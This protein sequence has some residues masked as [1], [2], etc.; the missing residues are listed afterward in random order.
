MKSFFTI[1]IPTLLVILFSASVAFA[2]TGS[3][4]GQVSDENNNPLTGA[5]IYIKE[6]KA[7]AITDEFGSFFL[8]EIKEGTYTIIV[9]HVGFTAIEEKIKIEDGVTN[10]F[11]IR[12]QF[13]GVTLDALTV[14]AKRTT[15]HGD[16]SALD[17]KL[18][19]VNTSQ[20]MLRL[21]PGLF[22]A[23]H[24]G[25]GKAEQ[26]FLRGF[27]VD[28][29]TD[30]NVT[31]DGMPVN[32]VSHAHGQGY[33]D[34]H[35]LIPELVDNMNF[36]KGPYEID[37]GN[38]TTAGWVA[39]KTKDALDNSFIKHEGG[40]YGYFR[41]L[42]G[43]NLLN[44][45][46]GNGKQSAYIAGEYAYNR[47]YFDAPQDF[48]RINIM[49]KYTASISENK[50][51]SISLSG[52]KSS[53]DASGQIPERAVAEHIIGRFGKVDDEN[54]ATSRYNM[55][56]NYTQSINANSTFKTNLYTS[57]YDFD[58]LSNFTFFLKDSINGDRIN[59]KEK[60]VLAGYNA[61]YATNYNIGTLKART[62][63][64]TGIRFD[65]IMNDEL[66]HVLDKN[67][68]LERLSLGDVH[69]TNMFGYFNETIYLTQQF[70][71]TAGTRF[72]YFLHSYNDKLKTDAGKKP[73]VTK[74]A[75][76]PK[77]GIFYNFANSGRIY[78][79]YG[80]GFHTNDTRVVVAQQ[81][82]DVLPLAQSF[83]LGLV[84]KP[85]KKL[86]ISAAI[87]QLNLQSEFVYVGDEAVVE[88]SGKTQ[89][90]GIDLSARYE[91]LKWLYLDGDA[92]YTHGRA[93]EEPKGLD[94]I[95]LAPVFT[96]IGGITAKFSNGISASIHYRYMGNRPANE[97]NSVT[98]KGYTIT[99]A[100]VNYTKKQYEIGAQIQNLFDIK[101]NEA[102]FDTET[103]LRNE[104]ASVSEICFTPGTPFFLKVYAVYKF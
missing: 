30:V 8:K 70:G 21:V 34:L 62:Q 9:S 20:D 35:F 37:K 67:T 6:T 90:N 2:H 72:D 11:K 26:I 12:M 66:S 76:S 69:E 17:I 61:D 84:L 38:L 57:Y 64:G 104:T 83:D 13:A 46:T 97:D 95:P 23:Q 48:S 3:I 18:R 86:L 102:Q 74:Q 96:S 60:R 42:A 75:F 87:W 78:F 43:I 92:N 71:L 10:D 99:D 33:A 54:G 59:Q 85:Y 16:M 101:W 52:F 29:G 98:A 79:N 5:G 40:T 25:G 73:L 15:I 47:G 39:F 50:R 91:I 77:A 28:H 1:A 94:Y 22:I 103:R 51:F 31:V 93:I 7:S 68:V 65:N 82:K 32:M 49:G 56:I 89:R 19:P 24:Q 36:G 44:E 80:T 45:Q 55:N 88:P 53:W 27:D 4:R 58:L 100:A 14:N 63:L 41:S 81:A